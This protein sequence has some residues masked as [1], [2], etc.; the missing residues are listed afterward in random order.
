MFGSYPV[1]FDGLLNTVS[2]SERSV[3]SGSMLA[4][5][6]ETNDLTLTSQDEI[7]KRK[8]IDPKS[9]CYLK[10]TNICPNLS[11]PTEHGT[12]LARIVP[13]KHLCRQV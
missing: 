3:F 5:F 8:H 10:K 9:P 13:A 2:L 1:K 4:S 6:E 12:D 11:L 7:R